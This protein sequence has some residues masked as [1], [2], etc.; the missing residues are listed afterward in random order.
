[1]NLYHKRQLGK[2]KRRWKQKITLVA[3]NEFKMVQQCYGL[4]TPYA[5]RRDNKAR[6]LWIPRFLSVKV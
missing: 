1:M 6:V 3:T 5:V 2:G 4:A